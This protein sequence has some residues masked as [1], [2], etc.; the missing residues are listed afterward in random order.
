M[1]VHA[2]CRVPWQF[3]AAVELSKTTSNAA[4]TSRVH[5]LRRKPLITSDSSALCV[6]CPCRVRHRSD[7]PSPPRRSCR[8]RPGT[9][10]LPASRPSRSDPARRRHRQTLMRL[11]AKP[12]GRIY[13]LHAGIPLHRM[14]S[15]EQ[16][17]LRPQHP[18]LSHMGRN[19]RNNISLSS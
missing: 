9:T 6:P 13:L 16:S 8:R 19:L 14:G 17:E 10:A 1:G 2:P 7:S 11:A 4:S 3:A 12:L 18:I 15:S 5:K